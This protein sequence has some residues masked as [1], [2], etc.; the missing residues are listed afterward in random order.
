M[1]CEEPPASLRLQ[2]TSQPLLSALTYVSCSWVWNC[3]GNVAEGKGISELPL[4]HHRAAY[5][6]CR[7][8]GLPSPCAGPKKRDRR[9]VGYSR[10]CVL[11][12]ADTG[13]MWQRSRKSS[14]IGK[15]PSHFVWACIGKFAPALVQAD[16][17]RS[18]PVFLGKLRGFALF[19]NCFT[20]ERVQHLLKT[21]TTSL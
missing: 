11:V 16:I 8:A 3:E 19:S 18:I 7:V 10:E 17:S 1:I 21:F 12:V 15:T 20:T 6:M 5:Q 13:S 4:E 2:D 9:R 14:L